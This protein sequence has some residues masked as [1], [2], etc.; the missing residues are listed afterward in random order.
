MQTKIFVALIVLLIGCALAMKPRSPL[1]RSSSP[2]R[3]RRSLPIPAP[4]PVRGSSP[5][6]QAHSDARGG[7]GRRGI[8]IGSGYGSS[9]GGSGYDSPGGGSGGSDGDV[10]GYGSSSGSDGDGGGCDSASPDKRDHTDARGYGTGGGSGWGGG[11][12]GGDDSS[13]SSS[14]GDYGSSGGATG[15]DQQDAA[16]Q[17]ENAQAYV[18]ILQT[19]LELNGDAVSDGESD[20]TM[21]PQDWQDLYDN[22]GNTIE[23]IQDT[24]DALQQGAQDFPGPGWQ[25]V[26]DAYQTLLNQAQSLQD[27]AASNF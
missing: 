26:I 27:R 16:A 10:R 7:G 14:S 18:P 1:A 24:L 25:P 4:I 8:C 12:T 3:A 20:P 11:G 21:T 23:T 15:G 6:K 5:V 22:I 2:I 17:Q 9:G 19:N 13:S